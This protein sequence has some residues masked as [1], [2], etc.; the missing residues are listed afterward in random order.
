MIKTDLETFLRFIDKIEGEI[1]KDC[2]TCK[3]FFPAWEGNKTSMSQLD[4]KS[5]CEDMKLEIEKFISNIP[6]SRTR[7]VFQYRYIDGLSWLQ[8]AMRMNKVHESYP[9]KIHDRYLE[10]IK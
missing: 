8:I 10:N 9:R 5:K 7:R 4:R 6:D 3:H 2:S 1:Y